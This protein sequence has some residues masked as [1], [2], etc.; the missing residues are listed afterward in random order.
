MLQPSE[1]SVCKAGEERPPPVI[2]IRLT[3][4]RILHLRALAPTYLVPPATSPAYNYALN[5]GLLCWIINTV[6]SNT[7]LR[8]FASWDRLST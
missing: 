1:P 8:S 4:K 6:A 5:L 3:G 2:R 7:S